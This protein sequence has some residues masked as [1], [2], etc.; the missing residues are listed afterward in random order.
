MVFLT[1]LLPTSC[2]K[3]VSQQKSAPP[4]VAAAGSNTV[5]SA[6]CNFGEISLTN[7]D[8]T[9]LL[10]ANGASCTLTPRMLDKHDVRITLAVESKND[11][12]ETHNFAVTQVTAQPGKPLEVA[13][14]GLNITF[15]PKV[16]DQE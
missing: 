6:N 16:V 4:A 11:Y 13:V 5:N 3:V 12:G 1:G 9:C 2:H 10:L 7:H 8:E 15:T 14:G